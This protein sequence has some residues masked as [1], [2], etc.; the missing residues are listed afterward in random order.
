M[1]RTTYDSAFAILKTQ[2]E[3]CNK[4]EEVGLNFEYGSGFIGE[5]F[6][7][8][9]NESETIIRDALGLHD[10]PVDHTCRILGVD[11]PFTDYVLYPED[12]D[13]EWSI[14]ADDFSEFFY[15]A[16]QN[17]KI[18]DVMWKAMVDRD[19]SAK[20]EFNSLKIGK[21]GPAESN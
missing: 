6:E 20:T 13:V 8:L 4:L 17:E 11:H 5:A 16:I 10:V 15:K 18:Q 3:L 9:L 2:N 7:T 14:T 12:D 21:I 19:E 1:S